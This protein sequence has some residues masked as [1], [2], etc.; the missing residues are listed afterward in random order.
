MYLKKK[1][2]KEIFR[3]SENAVWTPR[4]SKVATFG[5][6]GIP[7]VS[8][9]E[10]EIWRGPCIDCLQ[11]MWTHG[12]HT[13]AA[14]TPAHDLVQVSATPMAVGVWIMLSILAYIFTM[15]RFLNMTLS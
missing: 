6:L 15:W 13:Q 7:R 5:F 11:V 2:W 8:C 1:S 14:S 10:S 12:S 3:V 4:A 9:K